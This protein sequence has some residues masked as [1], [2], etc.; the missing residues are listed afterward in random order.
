MILKW[1]LHQ[2][3]ILTMTM[4]WSEETKKPSPMCTQ[5]TITI[6]VESV[7]QQDNNNKGTH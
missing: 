3:K 1:L 4:V 5:A 7:K 2:P 6:L